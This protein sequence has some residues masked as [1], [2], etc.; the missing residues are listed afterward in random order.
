MSK[1][2]ILIA[3]DEKIILDLLANLFA[4]HGYDILTAA[5]GM[6]AFEIYKAEKPDLILL[7]INMPKLNGLETL[8]RIRYYDANVPVIIHTGYTSLPEAIECVKWGISDCLSKPAENK[9]LL[10]AAE[11]A[12]AEA[13]KTKHDLPDYAEEYNLESIQKLTGDSEAIRKVH[14]LVR[15]VAPHNITVLLRGESGTGKEIIAKAIHYNSGRFKEHLVS[16][17]CAALPENLVESELFG[18]EKGA[19]TGADKQKIGKFETAN[20]GTLFLDEIG[21]LPVSTQVKLLRVLQEREIV[22]VGGNV[23]V[24]VDVRII[25]ATNVNLEDNIK[26]GIFREDLYHRLSE[27]VIFLPSLKDRK[28]DIFFM[29]EL[30]LKEFNKEFKKNIMGFAP[31]VKEL[32]SKYPWPGNIR[33]LRNVVKSS[34]LV[35]DDFIEFKHLPLNIQVV[36]DERKEARPGDKLREVIQRATEDIEKKLILQ[37]LKE[38]NWNQQKA[39]T[40]LGVDPKTLYRKMKDYGIEKPN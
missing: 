34:T 17:D 10:A 40:E 19:F 24:K 38:N 3:D 33:E 8:K 25:T 36:V 7:D 31:R 11:K 5:N 2:R 37:A 30:F 6:E 15:K 4:E 35:A 9:K 16:V 26:K 39:A 13:A 12:I 23:A 20:G 29:L 22:R 32:L 18:Y 21:N 14:E 28:E 1:P 27:F